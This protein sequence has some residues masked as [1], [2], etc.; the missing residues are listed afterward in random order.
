MGYV[1]FIATEEIEVGLFFFYGLFQGCDGDQPAQLMSQCIGIHAGLVC[2]RNSFAAKTFHS[3]RESLNASVVVIRGTYI[4]RNLSLCLKCRLRKGL[5]KRGVDS[6]PR[7]N[8]FAHVRIV[9]QMVERQRDV[10]ERQHANE[11]TD[12]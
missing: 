9:H 1:A 4:L 3:L 2:V 12:V 10:V 7:K 11:T 5:C 8:G 6:R